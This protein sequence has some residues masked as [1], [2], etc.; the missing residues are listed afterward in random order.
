MATVE[1]RRAEAHRPL[2][3]APWHGYAFG[4]VLESGEPFPGIQPVEGAESGQITTWREESADVITKAWRPQHGEVLLDLRHSDGRQFLR[5]DA[6]EPTG[7]R[8]WAPYYGRHLVSADG[9]EIASALPRVEPARWQR[10]FFAQV[11]PLA[12]VLGGLSA[13]RASAVAVGGRVLA[14]VGPPTSGKTSFAAHLVGLGA[15]FVTDDVLVIE[16]RADGVLAH[17]GP[18]RLNIDE[19]ELRRVPPQQQARLGPLVGRSDKLML[20]PTPVHGPL[21]VACFYILR[22]KDDGARIAIV[23]RETPSSRSLLES[24]FPRYLSSPEHRQ[25]QLDL[26][27]ELAKSVPRY[28]VELPEKC[29]ARDVAAR[30]LAHCEA[31][32]GPVRL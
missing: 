18:A 32:C 23:E 5:I 17:P 1:L 2:P 12:A 21:P 24:G 31:L 3:G 14:F 15:T 20:E 30:V 11:L 27:A 4:R 8:I 26:C 22:P 9:S 19:A 13:F 10:L 16:K 25:R 7:Y 6:R 28:A 29:R